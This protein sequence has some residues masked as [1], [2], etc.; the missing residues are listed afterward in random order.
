ME[1]FARV[2]S[3]VQL[4]I[5]TISSKSLNNYPDIMKKV[6]VMADEQ[7]RFALVA[8]ANYYQVTSKAE[9]YE[10]VNYC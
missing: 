1:L 9:E 5:F 6:Q 10:K 8:M 4:S 3:P 2:I 7:C